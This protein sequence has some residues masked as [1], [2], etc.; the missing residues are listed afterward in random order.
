MAQGLRLVR[1]DNRDVG[2]SQKLPELGVPN[3]IEITQRHMAGEKTEFAYTL[4]DMAADAAAIVDA[5]D[6]DCVHVMGESMGGMIAQIAAADH[7]EKFKSLIGVMTSSRRPGLPTGPAQAVL[8]RRAKNPDDIEEVLGISA[9][10]RQAITGPAFD[11]GPAYHAE[12]ARATYERST[13]PQGFARHWAAILATPPQQPWLDK[14]KQPVLIIHGREDPLLPLA[15]GEDLAQ[16]LPGSELHIIDG[17][18]H[19][20]EPTLAP[21][22]VNLVND[23]VRRVEAET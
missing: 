23:F 16:S 10:S 20:V 14:I 4:A 1:F 19:A 15:H 5:L 21:I 7:P 9:E 12:K 8:F 6:L 22:L 17:M 2:L 3:M 13:Y 18:G 11:P